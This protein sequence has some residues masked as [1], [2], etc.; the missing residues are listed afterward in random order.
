MADALRLVEWNICHVC[1]LPGN[2]AT[3]PGQCNIADERI[4]EWCAAT[5]RVLVTIDSDFRERWVRSGLLAQH[6]V[7]T[8]VFT[9][10]LIG[11]QEQHRRVTLSLPFWEEALGGSPYGHQVWEQGPHRGPSSSYRRKPRP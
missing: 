8:I 11:L 7:E 5:E 3:V 4:A 9:K 10:D 6:G 1:A 2:T